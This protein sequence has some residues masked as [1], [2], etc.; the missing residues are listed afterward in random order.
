MPADAGAA[1]RAL[2]FSAHDDH[3]IAELGYLS[4]QGKIAF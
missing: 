2:L 1:D 4:Q 3:A